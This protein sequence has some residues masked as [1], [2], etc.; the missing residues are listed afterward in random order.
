MSVVGKIWRVMEGF[1]MS[2][3]PRLW[4]VCQV[5][6]CSVLGRND[7]TVAVAELAV[8]PAL[9]YSLIL[10]TIQLVVFLLIAG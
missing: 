10:G 5:V 8:N 3:C 4:L 6:E 1:V 9:L 2:M 7:K